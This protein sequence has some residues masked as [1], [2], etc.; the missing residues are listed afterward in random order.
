MAA[1][2]PCDRCVKLRHWAFY[3]R[4]AFP[5]THTRVSLPLVIYRTERDWV[6]RGNSTLWTLREFP[7]LGRGVVVDSGG[8]TP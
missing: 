3:H 4:K 1:S 8:T 6:L 7:R 2:A 5:A